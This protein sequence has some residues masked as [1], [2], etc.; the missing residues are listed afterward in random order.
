M[1]YKMI[2]H[3]R[4]HPYF[5]ENVTVYNEREITYNQEIIIPDRLV[6][7]QNNQVSIIDYK[8]GIPKKEYRFQVENYASILKSLEYS[9]QK[10][11]LI[12]IDEKISIDEF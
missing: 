3:P 8:T 11:V 1:L 5:S 12:Y 10:K 9:I 4:I 2:S 7:H 6:F